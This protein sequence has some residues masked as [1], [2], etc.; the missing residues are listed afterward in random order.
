MPVHTKDG[1]YQDLSTQRGVRVF[2]N[3]EGFSDLT[4]HLSPARPPFVD[5]RPIL[6][7]VL[8]VFIGPVEPVL[9]IGQ[10]ETSFINRHPC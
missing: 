8:V 6:S 7:V 1:V 3:E 9:G 4:I 2:A 10:F 5:A